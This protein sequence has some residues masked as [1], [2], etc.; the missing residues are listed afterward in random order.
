MWEMTVREKKASLDSGEIG[1]LERV[2][3]SRE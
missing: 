2:I 1:K 3:G